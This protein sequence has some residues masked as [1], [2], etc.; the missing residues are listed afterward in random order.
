MPQF[1]S[2]SKE[3]LSQVHPD[4]LK[5]L[6][7]A[8]KHKDFSILFGY[9]TPE[10]QLEL[11]KKGRSLINNKWVIINKKKVVTYKDGYEKKSNHNFLPSRAV[12]ILP[13]PFLQNY[14]KD[15]EIWYEYYEVIQKAADTVGV[16]IT[17]GGNWKMKDMPHFELA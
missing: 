17:W 4:L 9:R 13:Y 8:I 14:W 12:D 2:K 3:R 7:E 6:D 15:T 16:K 1:G 10:E 5:V 11:F